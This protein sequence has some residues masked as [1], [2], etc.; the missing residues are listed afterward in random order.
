MERAKNTFH[1]ILSLRKCLMNLNRK[2]FQVISL[3]K[4]VSFKLIA[5]EP[6]QRRNSDKLVHPIVPFLL[7]HKSSKSMTTRP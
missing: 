5:N 2:S 7:P 4:L 3:L 1:H 6:H